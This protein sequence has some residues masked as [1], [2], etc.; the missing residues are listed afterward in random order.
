M[1]NWA[2][3]SYCIEGSKVNIQKIYKIID[4]FMTEKI[5]PNDEKT[6]KSWEGNILERLGASEEQM[7]TYYLRGFIQTYELDNNILRIAAEEAW[8]RNRL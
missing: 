1:A 7:K 3:T 6:D 4:G 5:K 2:S 8:G